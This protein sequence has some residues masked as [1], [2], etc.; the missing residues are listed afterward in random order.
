MCNSFKN[1]IRYSG[2]DLFLSSERACKYIASCVAV[3]NL[4]KKH[5]VPVQLDLDVD[6]ENLNPAV[7]L[8]G[9]ANYGAAKAELLACCFQQWCI[10]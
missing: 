1:T 5:A 9:S 2:G 6:E 4:C 8:E 10:K 3:H 7:K